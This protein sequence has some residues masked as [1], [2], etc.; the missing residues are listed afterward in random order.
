MRLN[1]RL[2]KSE[3]IAAMKVYYRDRNLLIRS[4]QKPDIDAIYR[5]FLNLGWHPNRDIYE[6][7]LEQQETGE[8]FVFVAELQQQYCGYVT[9]RPQAV[10]GPFAGKGIPE[11][12]DFNVL[13][14]YRRKGIGTKLLDQAETEAFRLS[15]IVSLGVGLH[16]G[17][18]SAQRMYVKRGYLPDGSGVWYRDRQLIP[19][20][21]CCNDDDL[22][23]YLS[24][25]R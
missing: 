9:L 5:E 16:S 7:Y 12:C 4:M 14:P 19:Y 20:S 21:E 3:G 6:E 23:L 2:K 18:G 8:R 24:K 17:Y 11:I 13:P 25:N 15:D 22:V 10:H 1:G